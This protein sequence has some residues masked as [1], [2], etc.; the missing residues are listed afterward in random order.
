[1]ML[2]THHTTRGISVVEVVIGVSIA[3]LIMV[4]ASHAIARAASFG[5]ENLDRARAVLLAEEG[6]ELMRYLRDGSWVAVSSMQNGAPYSLSISTTTIA[7]TTSISLIDNTY[8]RTITVFPAYRATSGDDL[9]ASTSG[10]SKVTDTDT[11]LVTVAVSWWSGGATST[12][13][14]SSYL[15]NI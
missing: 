1:M 4:Y 7:T 13:S 3:A 11:K 14:L 15:T 6:I 2:R 10:V 8:R 5:R 12:V 9:V